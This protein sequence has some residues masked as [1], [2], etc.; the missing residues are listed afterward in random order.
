MP[1]DL[2]NLKFP[3]L[4]DE[5]GA[6][7]QADDQRCQARRRG[8]ERDVLND[9]QHR[10]L[11]MKLKE[12]VEEHQASSAL[13]RSTT[14]SVRIPREPFTRTRSPARTRVAARSAASLLFP[15]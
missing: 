6:Q 7:Q 9:V 12:E 1:D 14:T 11:R 3:E 4:A 8:T 2:A 5:P 15:T 13:R 10:Y